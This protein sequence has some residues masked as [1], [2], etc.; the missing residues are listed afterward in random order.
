[1]PS[2]ILLVLLLSSIL[3]FVLCEA[4]YYG[5]LGVPK[6][7][8]EKQIKAAYRSLSK[9][10]HPDKNPGDDSAQQK[11]IE[12]GAAYEVLNDPDKR[13]VYDR[14]GEE[15][16]KN[17]GPGGAQGGGRGDPFD[18]FAN[19]F[20]GAGRGGPRGGRPG[21]PR[22]GDVD[23]SVEIGLRDFYNGKNLDFQADL[24]DVCDECDGTGS[25]DGKMHQC[26]VCHG[27]GRVVQKRQLAPGMI[28]QFESPCGECRGTGKKIDHE[29][30]KCH[31]HGVFINRRKY[32]FKVPPGAERNYVEVFSGE[33]NKSPDWTAGDLRVVVH[34]SSAGNLG[35][36][37]VGVNLYRTEVI[38]MKESLRG[39]WE[40]YIPFLDSYE[41]SLKLSRPVG[42]IVLNGDVEVI[43]GKG[44]PFPGAED[45]HGDLFVKYEVIYPG[46]DSKLLKEIHDEL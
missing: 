28:Q 37:R 34:E 26:P 3:G 39:G 15:G 29:C 45:E 5:V 44:M 8:D 1:M 40:R 12:I 46:G 9:Q 27:G 24:Q 33:S 41:Q 6:D 7:A 38:S 14:Y 18:I 10:Y 22:G 2:P 13:A 4:D 11:F 35:Y 20:G 25:A 16:L 42:K 21:K 23:T 19:F 17:G 31:G 32:D 36:R 43:K 30:N